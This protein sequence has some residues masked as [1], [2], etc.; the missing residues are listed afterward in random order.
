MIFDWVNI[1]RDALSD[2]FFGFVNF[3]PVLFGALVVFVIG[4]FISVGV[5]KLIADVL[6]KVRFNQ[7]FERGNWKEALAKADIKVEHLAEGYV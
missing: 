2:L 6:K 7:V 5:G 4:W 1:T 3:V